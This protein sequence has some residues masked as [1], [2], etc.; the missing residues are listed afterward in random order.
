MLER[1][2]RLLESHWPDPARTSLIWWLAAIHVALVLLVAGGITWSA[3]RMLRELADAQGKA[4]VQLAASHQVR[5]VL[6]GSGQ[7]DSNSR[8]RRS[9]MAVSACGSRCA[10]RAS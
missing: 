3:S 2:R 4:R 7:C 10:R 1:L 9:S 6:A 8:R 5:L